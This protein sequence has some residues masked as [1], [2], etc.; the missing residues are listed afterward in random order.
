MATENQKEVVVAEQSDRKTE[1]KYAVLQEFNDEEKESWLFFIRY[2]GNEKALKYLGEQLEKVEFEVLEGLSTFDLE[3]EHLVS[4]R[5][6]KEMTDLDLNYYSFHR[7]FDGKM[8][9]I[10][11]HL[12]PDWKTSKKI[13]KV[14][15]IL[16]YGGIDEYVSDEDVDESLLVERS[17]EESGSESGTEE[18]ESSSESSSEQSDHK[19]EKEEKE[20][21]EEDH[22]KEKKKG[23]VPPVLQNKDI[24]GF[25]RAKMKRHDKK[26]KKEKREKDRD[27]KKEKRERESSE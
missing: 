15:D 4:E 17:E 19:V 20:E 7:K 24:P 23:K 27:K 14:N 11:L 13:R 1:Y 2:E 18:E 22:R 9:M 3:T 6:A 12:K 10:D 25:A 8:K 21:K 5:T 26:E 16:G